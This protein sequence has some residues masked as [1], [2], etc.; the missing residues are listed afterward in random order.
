MSSRIINAGEL[1]PG[2]YVTV[3][4]P[5]ESE[6]TEQHPQSHVVVVGGGGQL[7]DDIDRYRGTVLKVMAVD[8]PFVAFQ[9][10][11]ERPWVIDSRKFQFMELKEEFV[12]AVR[13]SVNHINENGEP[14]DVR[15][16]ARKHEQLTRACAEAFDSLGE[17]MGAI[18]AASPPPDTFRSRL[19]QAVKWWGPPVLILASLILNALIT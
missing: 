7:A 5:A 16:L 2:I 11:A 14:I 12:A 1:S 6:E 9:T 8:L 10:L 19:W 3:L 17:K 13:G 18:I 15:E 4:D